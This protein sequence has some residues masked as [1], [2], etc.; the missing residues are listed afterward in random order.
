MNVAS[1]RQTERVKLT[2]TFINGVAI[3]LFAVGV[4]TPTM[5]SFH[6]N[7]GSGAIGAWGVVGCGLLSLILHCLA[8]L[9][10]NSLPETEE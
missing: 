3:A 1:P 5:A 6:P 8:W 4:F 10:L 2:A 7:G 9:S